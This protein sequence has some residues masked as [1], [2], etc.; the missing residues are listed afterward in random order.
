RLVRTAAPEK[1]RQP[2]CELE[3]RDQKRL[4]GLRAFRVLLDAK[5][6]SRIGE[7]R[8]E[9]SLYSGVEGALPAPGTVESEQRIDVAVVDGAPVRAVRERLQNSTRARELGSG[10][11]FRS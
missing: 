10:L 4:P 3:I 6:E 5:H 2:R 11:A 8:V 1:E 9:R 7:Y